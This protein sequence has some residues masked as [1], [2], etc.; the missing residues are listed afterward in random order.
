MVAGKVLVR[1]ADGDR[2]EVLIADEAAVRTEAQVQAEEVAR[3]VTSDP[4]HKK[5]ALLK[6]MEAGQL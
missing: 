1:A 2:A 6:A 3:R 5:M 4:V